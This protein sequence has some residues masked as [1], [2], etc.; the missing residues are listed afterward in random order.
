M[1]RT[2]KAAGDKYGYAMTG[3]GDEAAEMGWHMAIRVTGPSGIKRAAIAAS[4]DR[5]AAFRGPAA[6]FALLQAASSNLS[7][8]A[9]PFG[10]G[11]PAGALPF[12]IR[13]G[14]KFSRRRLATSLP[15]QTA[16]G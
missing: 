15:G 2:P 8:D 11:P 3:R 6:F 4:L 1:R 13:T 5:H 14:T 7:P 12:S 16:P 10:W 9:G